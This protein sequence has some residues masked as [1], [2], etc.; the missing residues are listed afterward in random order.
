M[1]NLSLCLEQPRKGNPAAGSPYIRFE[2][3]RGRIYWNYDTEAERD[4]EYEWIMGI[5]E[6]H[7]P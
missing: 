7:N 2:M 1:L 3:V 4:Q 6:K 5:L